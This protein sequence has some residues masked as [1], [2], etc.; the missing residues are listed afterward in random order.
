MPHNPNINLSVVVA[1]NGVISAGGPFPITLFEAGNPSS[2]NVAVNRAPVGTF[3]IEIPTNTNIE[4]LS[5]DIFN[6]KGIKE[7]QSVGIFPGRSYTFS[8]EPNQIGMVVATSLNRSNG[9]LAATAR[10]NTWFG[11]SPS[12]N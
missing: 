11:R 5:V 3:S 12:I 6:V 2:W 10:I 1:S 4:F 8:L 7:M 9:E